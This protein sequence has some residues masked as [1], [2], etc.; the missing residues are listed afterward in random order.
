MAKVLTRKKSQA[1]AD[2]HCDRCGRWI[3]PGETYYTWSFRY[4][5]SRFA[6]KEHYPRQSETTQSIMAEVYSAME[7]VED[8]LNGTETIEDVTALVEE[9]ASAA[10][11]IA[12]QYREA[13][14]PFGGGGENGDR[15]D[16]LEGW[17][18]ELQ[19]FSPEETSGNEEE[20]V[21]KIKDQMRSDGFSED[22]EAEWTSVLDA[23][24]LELEDE[25]D[26][27]PQALLD[28]REAASELLNECPI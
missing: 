14:E 19:N 25:T 15:A 22:D 1:G 9:V 4:G 27:I 8:Q 13:A 12:S 23:R 10:E 26:E 7:S 5:G 24:V 20:Q 16:Q 28:A 6:C 18:S 2:R 21:E 11:E 3:T 17:A